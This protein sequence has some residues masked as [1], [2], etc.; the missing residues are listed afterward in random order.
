MSDF[1]NF[2]ILLKKQKI[3]V[4]L[5][6]KFEKPPKLTLFETINSRFSKRKNEKGNRNTHQKID[7]WKHKNK[8]LFM[9]HFWRT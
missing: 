6:F 2:K 5:K 4:F 8:I 9:F 1:Q 7:W 3:L